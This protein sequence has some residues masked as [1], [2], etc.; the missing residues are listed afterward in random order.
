MSKLHAE[1][2][3]SLASWSFQHK[4]GGEQMPTAV[5][6]VI[7]SIIASRQKALTNRTR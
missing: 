7:Y 4:E 3:A 2:S 1:C 6:L 5:S